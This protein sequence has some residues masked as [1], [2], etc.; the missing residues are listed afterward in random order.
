MHLRQEYPELKIVFFSGYS[1]EFA[2]GKSELKLGENFLQ[3]PFSSDQLLEII[4][5]NLDN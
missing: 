4:R 5:R 2:G 3:K 1:A